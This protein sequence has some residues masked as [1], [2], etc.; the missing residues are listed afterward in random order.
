[1]VKQLIVAATSLLIHDT[2]ETIQGA[3]AILDFTILV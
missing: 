1:M 2:P 3:Q